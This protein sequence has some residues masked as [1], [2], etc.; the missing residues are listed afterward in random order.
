MYHNYA[1]LPSPHRLSA[2]EAISL[3]QHEDDEEQH[4][5]IT[6][7]VDL[8]DIHK[9]EGIYAS[10]NR[11]TEQNEADVSHNAHP[12]VRKGVGLC[13]AAVSVGFDHP[14]HNERI[15]V[16]MKYESLSS[17]SNDE[18]SGINYSSRANYINDDFSTLHDIHDIPFSS[19]P[20]RFLRIMNKA[21]I[22]YYWKNK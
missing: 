3:E 12:K 20:P 11:K 22:G 1:Y 6:D 9:N 19:H 5:S 2:I 4:L 14:L 8:V 10:V 16:R 21:Q 7:N 17:D 13:L 15:R 18:N